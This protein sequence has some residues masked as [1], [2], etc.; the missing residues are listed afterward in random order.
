[1]SRLEEIVQHRLLSFMRPITPQDIDLWSMA[2]CLG[3]KVIPSS[4]KSGLFRDKVFL[5]DRIPFDEQRVALA[6]E[7]S[8]SELHV[9]NQLFL[10]SYFIDDQ[11]KQARRMSLY[12]LCPTSMLQNALDGRVF[13]SDGEIAP[14]IASEFNVPLWFAKKRMQLFYLDNR[15]DL[16]PQL[17]RDYDT[18]W[19]HPATGRRIY[20]KNGAMVKGVTN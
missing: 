12:L 19:E 13:R 3:L 1:M 6:H 10:A 5:D 2:E 9:G 16:T 17:G 18:V 4:T 7:L 14:Y 15:V 20:F 11:E 8:H